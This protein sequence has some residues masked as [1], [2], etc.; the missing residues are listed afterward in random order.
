MRSLTLAALAVS[1]ALCAC[2]PGQ[3]PPPAASAAAPSTPTARASATL[4][5]TVLQVSTVPLADLGDAVASRYGI[6]LRGEGVLLLVTV[7]NAA[8]DA[9][10]VADL[11][12]DATATVLPQGPVALPLRRIETAGLTDYIGVLETRLP[13]TVQ[14]RITA[15]H[16]GARA[17]ISTSADLQPR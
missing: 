3:P 5:D 12:L 9:I 8:G 1:I 14:F 7:R 17:E 4:G 10:D 13:A 6:D 2:S 11:Q 15:A 16:G